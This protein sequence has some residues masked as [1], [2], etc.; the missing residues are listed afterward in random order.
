M[1][2]TLWS[3]YLF[4]FVL[5]LLFFLGSQYQFNFLN[6]AGTHVTW[7]S[8]SLFSYSVQTFNYEIGSH[9]S[10]NAIAPTSEA[11]TY[12]NIPS[13]LF[14]L[15]FFG[16]IGFLGELRKKESKKAED[17]SHQTANRETVSR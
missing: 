12:I 3:A 5:F 14:W 2:K 17:K 1:S 9:S 16:N 6:Q 11:M 10:Y 15:Y 13:M 8:W 4:N 7:T